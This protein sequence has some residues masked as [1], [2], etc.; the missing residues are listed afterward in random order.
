[1]SYS[2]LQATLTHKI[3]IELADQTKKITKALNLSELLNLIRDAFKEIMPTAFKAGFDASILEALDKAID[4]AMSRQVARLTDSANT[5]YYKVLYYKAQS[6][7]DDYWWKVT[8]QVGIRFHTFTPLYSHR[9]NHRLHPPLQRE[10]RATQD[11][12]ALL[13][14]AKRPYHGRSAETA[15]EPRERVFHRQQTRAGQYQR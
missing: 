7:I 5:L 13:W 2:H 6:I 10:R 1:M 11:R 14:S 12:M 8:P 3:K 15:Y 4:K 9:P